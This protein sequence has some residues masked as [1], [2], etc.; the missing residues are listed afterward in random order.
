MDLRGV[1][2][3]KTI[4]LN[5]TVQNDEAYIQGSFNLTA[6]EFGF[7]PYQFLGGGVRNLD[8]MTISFDM[9]GFATN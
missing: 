3:T 2:K 1:T 8:Q 4:V 6:T 5:L 9:V 7:A